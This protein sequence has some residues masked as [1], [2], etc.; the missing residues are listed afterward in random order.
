MQHRCSSE[1]L[2]SRP[3]C[4]VATVGKFIGVLL[5]SPFTSGLSVGGD[6]VRLL[7]AAWPQRKVRLGTR[8][9]S[10][11][12]SSPTARKTVRTCL[13]PLLLRLGPLETGPLSECRSLPANV[14][15]SLESSP[16]SSFVLCVVCAEVLLVPSR[17]APVQVAP[18]PQMVEGRRL[19]R[20]P[21]TPR[22]TQPRRM[23]LRRRL[24]RRP[25][26]HPVTRTL[27]M[28]HSKWAK[29]FSQGRIVRASDR[30]GVIGHG[31]V[32]LVA[33]RAKLSPMTTPTARQ[34]SPLPRPIRAFSRKTVAR[35]R[36]ISRRLPRVRRHSVMEPL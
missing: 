33:L 23:R 7:T 32:G 1:L 31:S 9:I 20:T 30:Q 14:P 26:L 16:F 11:C 2:L 4:R 27:V 10:P 19:P 25:R 3:A 5:T 22:P 36:R 35:G 12:F 29:I 13:Q 18:H 34:W 8:S 24:S 15:L 21:R 28:V 6:N 17:A